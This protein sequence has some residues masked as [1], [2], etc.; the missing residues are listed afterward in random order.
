LQLVLP[1]A[2]ILIAVLLSGVRISQGQDAGRQARADTAARTTAVLQR[3]QAATRAPEQYVLQAEADFGELIPARVTAFGLNPYLIGIA[4]LNYTSNPGLSNNRGRGDLYFVG[5]GGAGIYPNLV[6]G[7]YLDGHVS[8]L[9]YQ[10]AH[11]SSL[12]FNYFNAGGGLDYVFEN[13]GDLTA[14]I[15]FEYER[16]LDGGSL[17][18]FFV[19]NSLTFS[20]YKDFPLTEKFHLQA[21]WQAAISLT[22]KPAEARFHEFD[23]WVG[24]R[25][26]IFRQL[27]LQTF[28]ILSLFHY[29]QGDTRTDVTNTVGGALGLDLTSWARLIASTSFSANN[30][31]NSFFEYTVV[32]VGGT[33]SL[34][35]RF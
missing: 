16:Y 32:N 20:L 1:R 10:Y 24:S 3:T 33:I 17:R 25:W 13:L 12:N 2:I 4:G 29:P 26:R 34:D 23:F 8:D 19:N 7:L 5:G 27:E 9:V 31:T 21:G 30:S 35:F 22:A 28:Y 18:E 15:R 6:G 11:F 14:S